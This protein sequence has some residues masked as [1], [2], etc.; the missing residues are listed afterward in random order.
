[1]NEVAAFLETYLEEMIND[2]K[3]N[4]AASDPF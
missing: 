1:M 4:I 3:I 2:S